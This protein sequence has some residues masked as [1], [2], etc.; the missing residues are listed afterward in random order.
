MAE[1]LLRHL[2][3]GRVD[4]YSAG[5]APEAAIHPGARATLERKFAIDSSGQRPKPMRDFL[6]QP[7]DFVI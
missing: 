6:G 2:S 7:F 4:V 1:A 5:T 3:K